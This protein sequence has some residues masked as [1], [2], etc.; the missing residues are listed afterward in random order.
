MEF[1]YV[2]MLLCVVD[3]YEFLTSLLNSPYFGENFIQRF[4]KVW[5]GLISCNCIDK[6][7]MIL[8][9]LLYLLWQSDLF[10]LNFVLIGRC[11]DLIRFDGVFLCIMWWVVDIYEFLASLF[12][13][14]YFGENFIQRFGKV[15]RGV[16][17]CNW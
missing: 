17:S 14:P 4:G 12:N 2:V 13:S 10:I 8:E 6:L 11:N 5:R 9:F 3:I 15:W 16:F 1:S 7:W